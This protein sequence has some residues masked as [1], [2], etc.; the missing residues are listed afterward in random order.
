MGRVRLCSKS[1]AHLRAMLGAFDLLNFPKKIHIPVCGIYA[2]P[3]VDRKS[4]NIK[5][6]CS[7]R[8]LEVAF[9]VC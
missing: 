6:L 7:I 2:N 1:D 4:S 9:P 8:L 5:M 3:K